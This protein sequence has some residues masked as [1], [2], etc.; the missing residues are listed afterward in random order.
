MESNPPVGIN[1]KR[2]IIFLSTMAIAG[3]VMVLVATRFGILIARDSIVYISAAR[4]LLEGKGLEIYGHE[5]M[6]LWAPF[7]PA[8]LALFGWIFRTDPL[9]TVRVF[10]AL[11][12][13]AIVFLA[14]RTTFRYFAGKPILAVMG[15]LATLISIPLFSI[16]IVGYS[17][18]LF[19]LFLL[20][21]F[22][23]AEAWLIHPNWRHLLLFSAF[24]SM[25]FLTRYIGAILVAWGAGL[26]FFFNRGKLRQR[27]GQ[28]AAFGVV[29]CVPTGLWMLRNYLLTRTLTGPRMASINTFGEILNLVSGNF[30]GWFIPRLFDNP[31]LILV[32]ILAVA[33]VLALL[34]IRGNWN[35]ISQRLREHD[36]QVVFPLMW[37]FFIILYTAFLII[38]AV[39][40]YVSIFEVR[41]WAPVFLPSIW[42][43]LLFL[44]GASQSLQKNLPVKVINLLLLFI[45]ALGLVF[46]F[47]STTRQVFISSNAG[48]SLDA[49]PWKDSQIVQYL[50]EHQSNCTIFSNGPDVIY[51]LSGMDPY[52]VPRKYNGVE[53]VSSLE[54]KWPPAGKAC[55]AWFNN[56]SGSGMFTPD[57]LLSITRLEQ[58]IHLQDGTIYIVA[59]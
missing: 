37:G 5:P 54:G 55:I 48:E 25:A 35:R 40:S 59:R 39:Y 14:G 36:P 46:P 10:Q 1:T 12:F 28:L 43:G 52:W 27:I 33:A 50:R 49:S 58:T 20:L 16:S 44:Q 56:L 19:I 6:T 30:L 24:I 3:T 8:L 7:Y 23:T 32:S 21:A 57:E 4:Y 51:F 15:T 41:M 18:P 9:N 42:I 31:F 22:V 34:M 53:Q 29:T 38:T 11:I 47:I 26:I 13:G 2:R 17:E 45:L